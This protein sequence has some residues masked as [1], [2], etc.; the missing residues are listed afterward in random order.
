MLKTFFLAFIP[1]FV[2][3]DALGIL[4]I[5]LSLTSRLKPKFKLQVIFQS[6]ITASILAIFFI[7]LGKAIFK[8]LGIKISDFMIA[9]GLVLFAISIKDI[10]FA[11]KSRHAGHAELA[12]VPLGTPLIVGPAVLTTSLILLDQYGL[13]I[14]LSSVLLNIFTAGLFFYLSTFINKL[15]GERGLMVL[16]KVA[17][18]FLAAIA[19]MMIRKGIFLMI[20]L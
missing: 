5:Y 7:I 20:S 2:A 4:P 17:H 11:D 15:L 1:L 10:L 9:G 18:L 12:A 3:V 14:T 16:S 13:I 8:F 6:M 19:V